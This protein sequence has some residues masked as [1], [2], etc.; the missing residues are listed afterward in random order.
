[1]LTDG[2]TT[3]QVFQG[4]TTRAAESSTPGETKETNKKEDKKSASTS[5]FDSVLTRILSPLG[6]EE[7]SE[8]E[9]FAGIMQE[10]ISQLKGEE[11]GTKFS[12]KL[13]AKK[14]ELARPDGVVS[15]EEAA[16]AAMEAMVADGTVTEAEAASIH[17]QSFKAAQLDDNKEALFDN[18][19]G[20]GDPT[21]AM[22][23]LEAALL[24]AR[25]V[26][27]KIDSGEE[28]AG[29]LGLDIG[30]TG[31]PNIKV[32][33]MEDGTMTGTSST[34]GT[35]EE[36]NPMDGAEGFLFKPISESNGN[37]VVLLPAA[38]S[39]QI[40][41]VVLK[42]SEDNELEQGTATGIANGDREHFRFSKP[43]GEYPEN[44]IVEAK[45]KDGS[46]K[47]YKIADPSQRYD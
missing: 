7:I 31:L 35:A 13:A 30:N 5:D 26:I 19:G 11:A 25:T 47:T 46:L 29:E 22:A 6:A 45:L 39:K 40:E 15:A 33:T 27:E 21:I 41:S 1:M 9:L 36:G 34:I 14:S 20:P 2:V 8:E 18:R 28:A 37:L 3:N 38:L 42:D 43:G 32:T 17:A 16:R 44:L 12:E 23:K 10:R 24:S 4:V